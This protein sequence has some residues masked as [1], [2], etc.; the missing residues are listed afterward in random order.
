MGE[1]YG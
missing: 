1:S